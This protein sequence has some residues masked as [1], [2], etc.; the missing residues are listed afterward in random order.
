MYLGTATRFCTLGGVWEAVNIDD[1]TR[2]VFIS[3][4]DRVRLL[5]LQ[6]II[7]FGSYNVTGKHTI[8]EHIHDNKICN[9]GYSMK[10]S[11]QLHYTPYRGV[12]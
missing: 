8:A 2:K 4:N 3:L 12:A 6:C 10:G 5:Q 11:K 1:C 9:Q 7:Y